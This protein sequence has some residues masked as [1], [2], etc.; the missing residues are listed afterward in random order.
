[1]DDQTLE[2]LKLNISGMP[3]FYFSVEELSLI[4]EKDL[5]KYPIWLYAYMRL[6]CD[7]ARAISRRLKPTE[8]AKMF[9][10]HRT[11]IIRAAADLEDAGLIICRDTSHGETYDLPECARVR[12]V[13]NETDRQR[14][15]K[16]N[17]RAYAGE[18]ERV[19]DVLMRRLNKSEQQRLKEK[20]GL[21]S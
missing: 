5:G 2:L 14:K 10:V 3:Y 17:E 8:V 18:K 9:G 7:N 20:H 11:T 16:D 21:L 4:I 6:N 12:A 13:A 1:M 19:E 15:R